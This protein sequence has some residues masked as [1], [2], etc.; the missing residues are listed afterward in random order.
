MTQES[1][2]FGELFKKYRLKSEF[3]TLAQFGNALAQEGFIYEDSIYSHWQKNIRV[4]KDR[5]LLLTL[6]KIFI[7]RGGMSSIKDINGF[8]ASA[9]QGYLTREE[10]TIIE[11]KTHFHE[12]TITPQNA[13]A[14]FLTTIQSK[15]IDRAGWK[16]MDIHRP[17]SIAAHSFQL[18]V[19][20]MI[21]ADHLGVNRDKLM[22]MA[23][24]H[25]IGKIFTED[26]VW[27]HGNIIDIQKR[28]EKET[29]ETNGIEA[30]FTK[31]GNPK[32]YRAIFEE[33]N[34]R[35]SVESYIFWQLDRLEMAVQALQYELQSGK[36]LEEFFFNTDL[37][38]TQPFLREIF[39]CVLAMRP[40]NTKE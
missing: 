17:E 32:E 2:T 33:M 3:S 13:L 38:L 8:I 10:L 39:A 35:K 23:V 6:V 19:M 28:R 31:L 27:S 9:G 36:H 7:E 29:I 37:R 20:A 24:T 30:I 22:K 18:C 16:I 25:G 34:Q 1:S 12:A 14:F 5:K 4:P 11:E 40:K 21:F 15:Q 26:L